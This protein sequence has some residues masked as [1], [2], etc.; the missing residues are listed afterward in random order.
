LKLRGE[1]AGLAH[2]GSVDIDVHEAPKLAS[3]VEEAV[4]DR[5]PAEGIL[6]ARGIQFE[7]GLPTGF[8]GED[9][10]KENYDD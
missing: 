10:R 7:A 3:L 2:V 6:D 4:G 9:L 1:S 8:G 5:E